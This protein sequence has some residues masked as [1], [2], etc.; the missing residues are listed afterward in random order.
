MRGS[1]VHTS[2][3]ADA[4]IGSSPFCAHNAHRLMQVEAGGCRWMQVDADVR[5]SPCF[6]GGA[7]TSMPTDNL[8]RTRVLRRRSWSGFVSLEVCKSATSSPPK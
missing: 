1:G 7:A 4:S 3:G 8:A 5:I 6:V 2:G